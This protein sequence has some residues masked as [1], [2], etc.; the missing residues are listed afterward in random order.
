[1][2]VLEFF[3]AIDGTERIRALQYNLCTRGIPIDGPTN[4]FCD[5]EAVVSYSTLLESLTTASLSQNIFVGP[6]IGMPLIQSLYC[7]A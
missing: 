6:S 7:N 2:F 5:N 3:A 1:M 4:M